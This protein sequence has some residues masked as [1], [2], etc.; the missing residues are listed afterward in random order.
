M[1]IF[2]VLKFE[3]KRHYKSILIF[4][5]LVGGFILIMSSIF[6]PT[7]FSEY[8]DIMSS[9]P[10]EF[11]DLI[12]GIVDL[13]IFEGFFNMYIFEFAWMWYG[14]YII[15]MVS[16]DIPG[17]MENKTIDLVLSKPI[18]RWEFVFGKQLQHIITI[19]SAILFSALFTII[20]I[21]VNP[22]VNANEVHIGGFI[23][24]FVCLAILLLAIESTVLLIST[25]LG[26]KKATI[27][28]FA[29]VMGL[30]FISAYSGSIPIENIEYMSFFTF[31]DTRTILVDGVFT[32]ALGNILIL[33]AYS[34]VLSTIAVVYFTK[35]DIPV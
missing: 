30:W 33:F 4:S 2:S 10:P 21:F 19:F 12:G 22:N 18:K 13:S 32:G 35:R 5:G 16:Q 3:L 25:T 34:V 28:G 29:I 23:L 14:L 26:R 24:S 31:F 6:E 20:A 1:E 8:N 27:V 15:L 11:L 7:L 17:E 9:V